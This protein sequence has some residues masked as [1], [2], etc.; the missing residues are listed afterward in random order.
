MMVK[1]HYKGENKM[2]SEN[3]IQIDTN[4]DSVCMLYIKKSVLDR[5]ATT[6]VYYNSFK[7]YLTLNV[8][9]IMFINSI[10]IWGNATVDNDNHIGWEI[11]IQ[12]KD[13]VK[14]MISLVSRI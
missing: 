14:Q 7:T 8:K 3:E 2:I 11:P 12:L 5:Y 9:I 10:S 1:P 4:V 6:A 13:T